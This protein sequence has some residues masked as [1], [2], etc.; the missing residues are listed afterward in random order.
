MK[1]FLAISLSLSTATAFSPSSVR[2]NTFSSSSSTT[3]TTSLALRPDG[4]FS[5]GYYDSSPYSSPQGD[6]FYEGEL[7][8]QHGVHLRSEG[9]RPMHARV[10]EWKTSGHTPFRVDSYS[11]DANARPL[12]VF[13]PSRDG[14]PHTMAIRNTGPMEFPLDDYSTFAGGS[15]KIQGNSLRTY[16]NLHHSNPTNWPTRVGEVIQGEGMIRTYPIPA[17][18]EEVRIFI[19]SDEGYDVSAKIEV[20]QGPNCVKQEYQVHSENG[21]TKP[22]LAVIDTPG[23]AAHTIRIENTGPMTY[24]IRADVQPVRVRSRT[25]NNRMEEEVGRSQGSYPREQQQPRGLRYPER[26]GPMG[27]QDQRQQPRGLPQGMPMPNP[28]WRPVSAERAGYN[29]P[30]VGGPNYMGGPNW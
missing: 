15:T 4:P 6:Y 21:R 7:D 5:D 8:R 16:S 25:D 27:R 29:N 1:N 9:G 17:D 14:S 19:T 3:T 30:N 2:S 26:R 10:E 28:A 13:S 12:R 24:P 23:Y 11:Q 22:F 20:L 18:V